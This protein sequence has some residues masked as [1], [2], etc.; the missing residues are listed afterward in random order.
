MT[1]RP[2]DI[3]EGLTV[4]ME[5]CGRT[6]V[7]RTSGTV[8]LAT[9]DLFMDALRRLG[10][11]VDE[12]A[13][14]DLAGTGFVACCAVRPLAAL[15]VRLETTRRR[16]VLTHARPVVRRVLLACDLREVL[17]D[18]ACSAGPRRPPGE[19]D[20]GLP[21]DRIAAETDHRAVRAAPV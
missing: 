10:A 20:P 11:E 2:S 9:L 8:D 18:E 21:V 1:Q 12:T 17:A 6:T 15:R 5:R 7:L 3:Q 14:V 19:D 13:V 4:E 16:L